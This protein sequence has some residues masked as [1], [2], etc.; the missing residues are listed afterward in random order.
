MLVYFEQFN[1]AANMAQ[2]KK[3]LKEWKREWKIALIEKINP[4][5]EDLYDIFTR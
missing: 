2:R 4:E 5:W 3:R 1:D